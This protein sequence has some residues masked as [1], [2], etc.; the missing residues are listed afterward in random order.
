MVNNVNSRPLVILATFA[1]VGF[2]LVAAAPS[3][4]AACAG[5]GDDVTCWGVYKGDGLTG[6]CG[7][8]KQYEGGHCTG[9]QV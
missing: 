3:A 9:F 7:G 8:I 5:L 2:A 4:S 1:L 6:L